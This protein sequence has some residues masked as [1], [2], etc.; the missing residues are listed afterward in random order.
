MGTKGAMLGNIECNTKFGWIYLWIFYQEFW[1]SCL[2]IPLQMGPTVCLF[3]GLKFTLNSGLCLMK[4]VC[5]N[6]SWYNVENGIQRLKEIR[7]LVWIYYA[8]HPHKCHTVHL[9]RGPRGHSLHK[10]LRIISERSTKL[11]DKLW[12]GSTLWTRG[13]IVGN[14]AIHKGSLISVELIGSQNS[15]GQ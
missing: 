7:M 11:P 2:F 14:V 9:T 13:L 5:Q 12:D 4:S 10:A 3:D 1:I 15:W 8:W 6:I